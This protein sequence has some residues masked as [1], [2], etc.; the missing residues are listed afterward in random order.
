MFYDIF[1]M[2]Y[3]NGLH[4]FL[5]VSERRPRAPGAHIVSTSLWREALEEARAGLAMHRE[6]S[7]LAGAGHYSRAEVLATEAVQHIS[8]RLVI[9]QS[10]ACIKLTSVCSV[11]MAPSYNKRRAPAFINSW[12]DG[13]MLNCP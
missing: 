10:L 13:N 11:K 3:V 12:D 5:H 1:L 4:S 8:K 6:A 2:G 9:L 7:A